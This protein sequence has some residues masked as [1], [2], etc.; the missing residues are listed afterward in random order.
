[1]TPSRRFSIFRLFE[2]ILC[3]TFSWPPKAAA[4]VRSRV[5]FLGLSLLAVLGKKRGNK[6]KGKEKGT[7]RFVQRWS[8]LFGFLNY[9]IILFAAGRSRGSSVLK[10]RQ[11]RCLVGLSSLRRTGSCQRR[12]RS[13]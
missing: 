13:L 11:S 12:A 6:T 10:F 5:K 3:Q 9:G 4:R 1:M 2:N 7:A 8:R